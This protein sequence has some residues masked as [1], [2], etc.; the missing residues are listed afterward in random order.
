MR[1]FKMGLHN[2]W[3]RMYKYMVDKDIGC[4][5]RQERWTLTPHSFFLHRD[6]SKTELHLRQ[7]A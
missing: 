3:K 6:L 7:V 5:D 1:M 2:R 4:R